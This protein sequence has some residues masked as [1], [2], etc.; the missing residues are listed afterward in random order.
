MGSLLASHICLT[1]LQIHRS[2]IYG[3]VLNV[4]L[5]GVRSLSGIARTHSRIVAHQA[6][7]SL[8][9]E[10]WIPSADEP[11]LS[12][13]KP[14]TTLPDFL[15]IMDDIETWVHVIIIAESGCFSDRLESIMDSFLQAYCN[16]SRS[17]PMASHRNQ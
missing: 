6:P 9:K 4:G 16:G 17:L 1:S 12:M 13:V 2:K 5:T 10:G 11:Q 14:F 7:Y 8:G 3:R 15:P